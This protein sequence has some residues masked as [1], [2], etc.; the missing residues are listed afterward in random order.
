MYTEE[1]AQRRETHLG[2]R[3]LHARP[4]VHAVVEQ[5]EAELGAGVRRGA[6]RDDGGHHRGDF[7][8]RDGDAD[9]RRP[10]LNHGVH[11]NHL[12][13]SVREEEGKRPDRFVGQGWGEASQERAP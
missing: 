12:G 8:H 6:V 13:A 11:P 5:K 3:R 2:E 7:F 1:R 4:R 9:G 10:H